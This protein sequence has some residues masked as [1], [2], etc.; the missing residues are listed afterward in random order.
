MADAK[1]MITEIQQLQV[2]YTPMT[3]NTRLPYIEYANQDMLHMIHMFRTE[4]EGK[5]FVDTKKEEGMPLG[6]IK[7]DNSEK[8]AQEGE[9]SVIMQFYKNMHL[10]DITH[11]IYHAEAGAVLV[12]LTTIVRI[13]L[14]MQASNSLP[15]ENKKLV[16][17]TARC[18]QESNLIRTKSKDEEW[19]KKFHQIEE[20]FI[21]CFTKSQ[22]IFS[23]S[24]IDKEEDGKTVLDIENTIRHPILIQKQVRTPQGEEKQQV[25][26]PIFSD[27]NEAQIFFGNNPNVVLFPIPYE[28]MQSGLSP[29]LGGYLLNPANMNFIITAQQMKA[30]TEIA[31]RKK[32][33]NASKGLLLGDDNV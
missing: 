23:F 7:V 31:D 19:V 10:L 6:M 21:M 14:T 1:A 33:E 18:L 12:P 11:V 30:W 5:K 28:K 20:D 17:L 22:F 24:K 29:N 4:E 8:P 16:G 25:F 9:M 3:L 13:N 32:R 15:V 26:E 2:F 27:I